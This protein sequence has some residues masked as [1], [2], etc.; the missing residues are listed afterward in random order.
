MPVQT[1]NITI[2]VLVS[3]MLLWPVNVLAEETANIPNKVGS[4]IGSEVRSD[5]VNAIFESL[6][7][8]NCKDDPE[9]WSCKQTK[10]NTAITTAGLL[11]IG[12][13][14]VGGIIYGIYKYF[15]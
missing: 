11:I 9:S 13:L 2:P 15:S 8:M 7:E 5:A 14:S 12:V 1:K 4:Q 6:E 10:R 3:F